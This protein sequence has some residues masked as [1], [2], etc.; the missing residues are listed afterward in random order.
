MVRATEPS[1]VGLVR[2][3]Q[4]VLT[5][6]DEIEIAAVPQELELLTNL[7][8]NVPVVW[9]KTAQFD[10]ESIDVVE[11]KVFLPNQFHTLHNLN[12]P[13]ACVSVFLSQEKRPLPL[14]KHAFFGLRYA[15]ANEKYFSRLWNL[16]Q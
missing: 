16:I 8:L 4:A 14:G 1:A 3:S 2:F 7:L 10:F 15:A 9:I 12:Q 13:A 5:A 6:R 11:I